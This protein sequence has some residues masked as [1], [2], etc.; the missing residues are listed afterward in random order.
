M[1]KISLSF[2]ESYQL[3][4]KEHPDGK[5]L[6]YNVPCE[7]RLLRNINVTGLSSGTSYRFQVRVTN[8]DTGKNRQFG[9]TSDIIKFPESQT[10]RILKKSTKIKDGMPCLYIL[11]S[12]EVTCF[13]NETF[14]IRKLQL[15]EY[16]S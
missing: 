7:K 14:R 10:L 15:G 2:N 5:W 13:R 11:P 4:Y 12:T 16:Q 8:S 1:D 6:V 3:R 9:P